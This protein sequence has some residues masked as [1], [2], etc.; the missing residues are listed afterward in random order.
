MADLQH[1]HAMPAPDVLRALDAVDAGLSSAE[2]RDRLS[3]HGPNELPSKPPPPFWWVF[4]RQFNSPLIYI[5]AAAAVFSVVIGE[6]TDAGF[7]VAVLLLNA[8]IGS[9]QEWRAEKAS[10]ALQ[11][12]I[13]TRAT[14]VR[15][16]ESLELPARELVPGD[17]V[18]LESGNRVPADIRLLSAHGLEADESLLT[19]ESLPVSKDAAWIGHDR[20]TLGDRRN[21]CHAGSVVVR[22]RGRG[23]VVATGAKTS[24]GALALD[25]TGREAG[26]PPLLLRMEKFTKFIGIAVLASAALVALLGVLVQNKSWGEMFMAAVALAVSAIPEGL[27]VTLTIVLAIATSR[28]ARRGVVVRKLAAVEGLGS[29]TMIASDKTGT[30]TA[31]ELT[32]KLVMLPDGHE[33]EVAGV[34]Y[35]PDGAIGGDVAPAFIRACVLCNEGTLH[36]AAD[37]WHWRGDPT[38]IALLAL[39]HK[40]GV[41]RESLE[42]AHPLINQIPFEPERKYAATFH[43][44]GANTLCCV[45]GAPER[46]LDMCTWA[47]KGGDA[48]RDAM[49]DAAAKLAARGFR[50]LGIADGQSQPVDAVAAPPEPR[51]LRFLGFVCMIDPLRD[52]VKDAVAACRKAGITV[53]MV[54]GDHPVTALAISRELGMAEHREQVLSGVE[55]EK[56]S[57]EQLQQRIAG[58]RV[59]ARTSPQ[60]KLAIVNAARAAGHFVAVTGDGVNDA[61]ALRVANIGVAMGKSGTDV[62]REAAE[63]VI[64]DDNFA[65]IVA[66]VEE[67]RVAYDNL[68]KVIFLLVSCGAAEVVLVLL[69]VATG[70]PLPL[71]PVQLLWLNL[72]TNGIQDKALALEPREGDVLDRKPKPPHERIFN[73]LMIERV[74]LSAVAMGVAGF[75]LFK[76]LLDGGMDESMARNIVL[77]LFVLFENVHIGNA[78]SE[79]RSLFMISPLKNPWLLAAAA[80]AFALHFACMYIPF[81]SNL[82]GA[83]PLD[84]ETWGMIAAIALGL[85]AVME[86]HK[87]IR[88]KWPV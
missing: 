76:V 50:V 47:N 36:R 40:A 62:A 52:G 86:L 9:V 75:A 78:R 13:V 63:L 10:S 60:Q 77:A 3:R 82:L 46:V 6:H 84:L 54:T 37:G 53:A 31:N 1:W 4:L 22:G 19:G 28:M 87:L 68:R 64:S 11:K 57:A 81:M 67:G 65:T 61:P 45:K 56:L 66:G 55:V 15:D 35:A 69:A 83:L 51:G 72:V 25:V 70:Y 16:G 33:L 85:L 27:P 38:D 24:V 5:L 29:C 49:A 34:G 2:A 80:G 20:A 88:R 59:F 58:T 17:I 74:L 21:M 12:L 71:L 73:R 44:D 79:T 42:A 14:V 26:K 41:T 7:I 43:R 32:V 30:L 8:I 23:A 18:W 48:A 39:G